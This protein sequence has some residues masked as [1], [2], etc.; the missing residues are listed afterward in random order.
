MEQQALLNHRPRVVIIGGGF[1]GLNAARQFRKEDV[2][3]VLVDRQNYHLFQPLLYQVATAG[4]SPADIAANLRNTLRKQKNTE[5]VIGE[6]KHID[7]ATQEV[8]FEEGKLHYDYLIIAAGMKHNYFGNQEKWEQ[9]AP[10]LKTVDEALDLRRRMLLAFEAAEYETDPKE[11]ERLL[12]FV[13]VGGGPTGVEM[14]GALAEIAREVMVHDFRRIDSSWA[15]IVLI[16]GQDRLLGA[17]SESSS[18]NALEELQERG[19]DVR[20]N[21][22]VKDIDEKGVTAGEQFIPA[23]N[24]VWAAGLKAETLADSLGAEQDRM[25]RVHIEQTLNI[26]GDQR[27]FVIGD[28]AHLEDEDYGGVLPGQAP[29]AIQQGRHAGKNIIRLLR[30]Q[31]L[32]PFEYFDKGQ[33]AT[34]GRASAVAETGKMKLTGFVA[35]LAWLFVHLLYLVSFRDRVSVLINWIYAYVGFRRATRFVVGSDERGL[36]QRLLDHGPTR[37]LEHAPEPLRPDKALR[38]AS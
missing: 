20:L 2:D 22:F 10:G 30:D 18:K 1:G 25:G 7:R 11:R 35:W 28:M 32:K 24:I 31:D 15:R 34:I 33:M 26:K 12:T 4:L 23:H 13:V 17:F 16:E 19:V 14:A 5:V 27:V 3:V 36:K 9:Y 6:V 37:L 38:E 21:T 29:V 8:V